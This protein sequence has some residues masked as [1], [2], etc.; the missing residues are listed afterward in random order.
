MTALEVPKQIPGKIDH[1][2][3]PRGGG[4][5]IASSGSLCHTFLFG[6]CDGADITL[7]K[8]DSCKVASLFL[9]LFII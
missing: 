2:L 8:P 1:S 6:E 3:F 4:W 5:K 9:F 7:K